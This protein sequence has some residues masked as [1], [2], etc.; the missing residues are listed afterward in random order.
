VIAGSAPIAA[1]VNP[2]T[3]E[4]EMAIGTLDAS[5]TNPFALTEN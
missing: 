3:C 1:A 4:V 2:E 5:V